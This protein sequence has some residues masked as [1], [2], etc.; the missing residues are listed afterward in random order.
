[1]T[2]LDNM[3]AVLSGERPER[4]PYCPMG[5]W[6]LRACRKLL[7]PDCFDENLY[8]TPESEFSPLPR[9]PESRRTAVNYGQFMRLSTLGVGKG[10]CLPFGH[11]GPGEI[12]GRVESVPDENTRIIR[13]EGGSTRLL[14]YNP[15][16][17]HYGHSMPVEGP[18]DLER[19]ELPDPRN[20]ARWQDIAA[21]SAA[22]EA[23]GIMP[24]G[25][26]MGF[27]SGI[28]NSFLD[29]QRLMLAFFDHPEFVR[30]LTAHLAGWSLACAEEM[31]NRGVRLIEVCDDLGTPEGLLVSPETFEEYFMP[32]YRRLF[33]L[34]R[35]RGAFVHMHSHGNIEK[36][37]PMLV[38][39][40][41]DILNPFDPHENPH[42]EEIIE[43]FSDRVVFC[44][45]SSS[46]YYLRT[47]DEIEAMF[48][49]MAE[50]GKRCRRGYIIMEHGFP[51]ELSPE[52]FRFILDLVEKYRRVD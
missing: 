24:A 23:A 31:L 32:W 12:I 28:H 29:F 18:A 16:A 6:N 27:F 9:T 11:G 7:P 25:K 46:D 44:G 22:F 14:R 21:D 35:S 39:A 48:A 4:W 20:P 17:V 50:L 52:K 38:D 51:E 15:Y 19:L 41:V 36:V 26:I 8:A 43:R 34:C 30:D 37:L 47:E 45:F 3:L 49:R 40:G 1:M 5:H 2:E 13:Y 33:E 10:G 42:L